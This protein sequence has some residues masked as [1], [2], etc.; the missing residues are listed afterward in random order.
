MDVGTSLN[1]ETGSGGFTKYADE[2]ANQAS[3]VVEFF[4]QAMQAVSISFVSLFRNFGRT[5]PD[6]VWLHLLRFA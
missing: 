6:R 3:A 1:S 4:N 5:P 2:S